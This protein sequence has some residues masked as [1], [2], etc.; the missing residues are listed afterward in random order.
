M[1]VVKQKKYLCDDNHD[2]YY[3]YDYD[4]D[5]DDGHGDDRG[6]GSYDDDV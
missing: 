5:G 2:D 6:C 3:L 4:A 1:M